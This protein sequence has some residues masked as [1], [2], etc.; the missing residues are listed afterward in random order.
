MNIDYILRK[1]A[2]GL[3]M[4]AL[5]FAGYLVISGSDQTPNWLYRQTGD[6]MQDRR[7]GRI[8][9]VEG[10]QTVPAEQV[11][12]LV[13]Q[14]QGQQA[15]QPKGGVIKALISYTSYDQTNNEI[16]VYGRA[17][18][19][20]NLDQVAAI[21]FAPGTT[22]VGDQCASSLEQPQVA[23]WQNYDSHMMAYA[24]QGNAIIITDYEGMRDPSRIHHYMV[25]ELEGRVMLDSL[26]ALQNWDTARG[27][28]DDNKLFAAGFSQGGHAAMWADKIAAKYAP[29]LKL[30][31]VIGF[32]PVSDVEL[33][34]ADATRGANIS[35]FGPLILASYGDYYKNNYNPGSILLP[36]KANNLMADVQSLCV[37]KLPTYYPRPAQTYTP[38]FIQALSTGTLAQRGF[39]ELKSDLDRNQAG[40]QKTTTA[41]LINQGQLDNVVLASQQQKA[42]T[43]ICRNSKGASS[44]KIYPRAT[45][46][47]ILAQSFLDTLGWI[48]AVNSGQA[49]STC[50]R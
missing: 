25:G 44:L 19:P 15:A 41:K 22:G 34:M 11:L 29:D 24:A 13:R 21:A 31:G 18:L 6:K 10:L 8:V 27:R 7:G 20:E 48:E 33:T 4:G 49:P 36:D 1:I 17:Y 23:N 50:R 9:Q 35:W 37:D 14:T 12:A 28:I 47:N 42:I 26:R 40:D 43:K 38:E 2:G 16:K 5:L 39:K 32:G 46:Y 3:I 45:H 30:K